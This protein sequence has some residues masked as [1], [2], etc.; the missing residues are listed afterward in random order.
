MSDTPFDRPLEGEDL[1]RRVPGTIP[2]IE[3]RGVIP[4][5]EVSRDGRRNA[6]KPSLTAKIIVYGGLAAGAAAA[7]AGAVMAVQT[8]V[9]TFSGDDDDDDIEAARKRARQQGGRATARRSSFGPSHSRMRF[10]DDEA[11][12]RA[13]HQARRARSQRRGP[14]PSMVETVSETVSSLTSG[15][16]DVMETL[17]AAIG[18]FRSVAS[19]AGGIV[20]QFHGAADQV[21]SMLDPG[22]ASTA[23]KSDMR[24]RPRRS[25]VVDSRDDE[26]PADDAAAHRL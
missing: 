3:S 15:S 25:D 5:G 19:Q 8:I 20:E 16:R 22:P 9:D 23:R 6:P 17:T 11:A 14:Q 12:Q 1:F 13:R 4:S 18:A 24:A 2:M 10:A 7:T 26:V 21:K